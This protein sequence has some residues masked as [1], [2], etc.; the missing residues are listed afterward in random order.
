MSFGAIR[1]IATSALMASQVKMQVASSNISN[2]DV[3]GYTRKTAVQVASAIA[4]VGTGTSVTA[5]TSSVNKYLLADLIGAATE[6]GA[7]T[8]TD[9]K[10]D[11]LQALFGST[12]SSD[13]TGTSISDTITS[14]QSALTSLAGTAESSTLNSLAVSSLDEVASELR[15]L[16][17]GV[18]DLRADADSEI[19]DAVN[20]A[21]T[22]LDTINELNKQI[23]AAK[24]LGQST[25]DLEDQRNTALQSL[26]EVMDVSY[27]VKSDGSMRVSTTSGTALV[28][29][30]VHHLSHM[31]AAVVTSATTFAG[32]MVSGK[33]IT[34]QIQS[35]TIGALVEQRDEVLPGIQ[36][37]LDALATQLIDTLNTA[38]NAG[39]SLPP[40]TTLAGTTAV[41]GSDALSAT[42][43]LR[44]ATTDDDGN[45]VSYGDIDL[46][47]ISTMDDLV[48]ALNG[49]DGISASVASGT[50]V[51]TST[52][53]DGVA[54]ADIDSSMSGQG[55]SDY[56]GLNDLLTGTDAGSIK[57]RSEILAGTTAFATATLD[58]S[59]TP[60]VGDTVLNH[61]GTFVQSLETAMADDS[62]YAATG[63]IRAASTDL[64]GYAALIV[65]DAAT[66]ASTAASK[67]ETKQSAYDTASD[68]LTSLTGVNVDEE[69]AALNELEQYYSSAAQ[70]LEVLNAMFDALLSAV[71]S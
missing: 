44:I 47:S 17:T 70:I 22:A 15:E 43:T 39:S 38:Y 1:S 48:T 31:P 52:N 7:A 59:G 58:T 28:D 40:P 34:T 8:V 25:A 18:Q 37:A 23:V 32:I 3:E 62:S 51:I 55:F 54:V 60:A 30:N 10:S 13:G 61:S 66:R 56:F 5:I 45:L 63:G 50:L 4:G 11:A 65:S 12:T 69:S 42:G 6:L 26:S 2:A 16:S 14:L 27:I 67:L 46:S 35:G 21:N 64:A 36:D 53:G 49:I 24:A 33:D 41:T 71:R 68:A 57:V 9:A 19:S 29:S 20:V